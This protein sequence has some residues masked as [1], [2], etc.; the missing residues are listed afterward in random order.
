MT[1][2]DYIESD[3]EMIVDDDMEQTWKEVIAVSFKVLGLCQHLPGRIEE[4]N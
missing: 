4:N 2:S 3:G 1:P